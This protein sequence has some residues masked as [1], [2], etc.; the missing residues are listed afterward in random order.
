MTSGRRNPFRSVLRMPTSSQRTSTPETTA[1]AIAA[2]SIDSNNASHPGRQAIFY[3]TDAY[4]FDPDEKPFES[5]DCSNVTP[6]QVRL[7]AE[8]PR[9][10]Q[11][12]NVRKIHFVS[13]PVN[14]RIRKLVADLGL[15]EELCGLTKTLRCSITTGNIRPTR[16]S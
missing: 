10:L 4:P 1:F 3:Y 8:A 13:D 5:I 11:D 2:S 9:R 14:E 6:N 12:L 15:D 7:I 16:S